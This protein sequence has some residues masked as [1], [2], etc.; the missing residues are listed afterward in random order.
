MTQR[1]LN[2]DNN[3]KTVKGE[4]YGYLT[5]ILYLEP[6]RVLC[7][8]S[9][10]GCRKG[11]LYSAG[12]GALTKIQKARRRKTQL[13]LKDPDRFMKMLIGDIA[14]LE[15]R[16]QERKLKPCVRL[17]GTSDIDIEKSCFIELL[18]TFPDVQFYDY[19]KDWSRVSTHKNYY[20]C[21]SASEHT[22]EED[23][24]KMLDKNCNVVVVFD[25]VPKTCY[26]CTVID[27]DLSDLRFKDPSGVIVG[28][29]AKGK[30]RK[31]VT[32]FV[33]RIVKG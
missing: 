8:F 18:E 16:A 27:G 31:D 32:G 4:K 25:C 26:G 15:W 22:S 6:S 24:K 23:I 1:L 12:R 14:E 11:C 2:I 5:G 28:L 7:P 20:L 19:T 17:N 10:A 21:Y 33:H 29:K 3:A 13:F 30:A 9:T